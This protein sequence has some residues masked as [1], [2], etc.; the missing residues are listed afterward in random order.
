MLFE[1]FS[2]GLDLVL[3]IGVLPG[4]RSQTGLRPIG[5]R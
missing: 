4:N 3:M 5:N 1:P 2:I